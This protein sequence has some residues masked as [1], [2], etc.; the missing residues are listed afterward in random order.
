MTHAEAVKRSNEARF[1]RY[2]M[3]HS[4]LTYSVRLLSLS[5]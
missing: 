1:A 5:R 4:Q 3:T 2:Y